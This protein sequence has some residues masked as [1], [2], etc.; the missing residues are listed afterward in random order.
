MVNVWLMIWLK[1][2]TV[3]QRFIAIERIMINIYWLVI[4]YVRTP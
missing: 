2:K 4:V 1:Q 3:Q